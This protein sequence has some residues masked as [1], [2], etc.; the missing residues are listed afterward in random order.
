[1][2]NPCNYLT[3]PKL[4]QVLISVGLNY[5]VR[6]LYMDMVVPNSKSTVR[7]WQ[8]LCESKLLVNC[9]FL[10]GD[11]CITRMHQALVYQ[12]RNIVS[13]MRVIVLRSTFN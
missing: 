7:K 13:V 12:L 4:L 10:Q 11:I 2:D 8:K 3:R 6:K 9:Y 5:I 1:M